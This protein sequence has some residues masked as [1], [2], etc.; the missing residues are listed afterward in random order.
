MKN[1]DANLRDIQKLEKEI[2]AIE[3]KITV[4]L[5]PIVDMIFNTTE[6]FGELFKQDEKAEYAVLKTMTNDQK[7]EMIRMF[8]E[9]YIPMLTQFN[10]SEKLVEVKDYIEILKENLAS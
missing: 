2:S 6:V 5:S 10:K 3:K 8:E 1:L 7:E 4:D 9:Q